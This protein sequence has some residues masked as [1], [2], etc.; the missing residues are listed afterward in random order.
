MFIHIAIAVE[1]PVQWE[2]E[3]CNKEKGK[4]ANHVW[5][6]LEADPSLPDG[7]GKGR[8]WAD[9]LSRTLWEISH[10]NRSTVLAFRNCRLKLSEWV[11]SLA[12]WFRALSVTV[13]AKDLNLVPRTQVRWNAST[14]SVSTSGLC[15]HMYTCV[16]AHRQAE[17][18]ILKSNL[19]KF[20]KFSADNF[21]KKIYVAIEN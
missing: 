5:K 7:T 19:L 9:S 11:G 6:N 15:C 1:K 17:T 8:S 2:G 13:L 16:H 12:Q 18:K 14:I 4:L 21:E 3:P 20:W 10:Q